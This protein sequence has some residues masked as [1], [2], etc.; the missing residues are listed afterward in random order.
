MSSRKKE[1]TWHEPG[2]ND[3][4]AIAAP[5]WPFVCPKWVVDE[6]MGV[7]FEER[8]VLLYRFRHCEEDVSAAQVSAATGISEKLVLSALDFLSRRTDPWK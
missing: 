7:S 3:Q 4:L 2:P 1:S 6:T 8:F 5:G